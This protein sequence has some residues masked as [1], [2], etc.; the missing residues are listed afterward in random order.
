MTIKTLTD[1]EMIEIAIKECP[2]FTRPFELGLRYARDEIEKRNR[3]IPVTEE[4]PKKDGLYAVTVI[5]K[6]DMIRKVKI[7]IFSAS[8]YGEWLAT[9]IANMTVIAWKELPEPYRGE[10]E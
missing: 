2:G 3:W 5:D 6:N 7:T 10:G 8:D 1:E 4:L 9:N